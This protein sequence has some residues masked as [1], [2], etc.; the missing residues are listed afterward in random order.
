MAFKAK[1][2]LQQD[3]EIPPTHKQKRYTFLLY[4]SDNGEF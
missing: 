3:Y 4:I 1:L 2:S